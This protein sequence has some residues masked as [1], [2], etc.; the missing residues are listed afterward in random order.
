MLTSVAADKEHCDGKRSADDGYIN[1]GATF[2]CASDT[3]V[4]IF[5]SLDPLR[6]QFKRPCD[7][8]R[9]WKPARDEDNHRS[10]DPIWNLEEGKNLRRYLDHKPTGNRV[11]HGNL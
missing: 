2:R 4:D 5:R 3:R 1:P 6:R 11:R 10:H 8:E 7:N 9:H